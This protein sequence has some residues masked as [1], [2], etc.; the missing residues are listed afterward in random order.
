MNTNINGQLWIDKNSPYKL[1]YTANGSV[2]EMDT[3]IEYTIG[4]DET[5]EVGTLLA[6][7]SDIDS[8][9]VPC[10]VRKARFPEDL[11]N[12]I[13]IAGNKVTLESRNL[14]IMRSG[15]ISMT[16]EQA[17]NLLMTANLGFVKIGDPVYWY[18]GAYEVMSNPDGVFGS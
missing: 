11:D 6:F 1:K 3:A 5:F 2:F 13:G 7:S 4:G 14:S 8:N 17:M 9:N 16:T 12:I 18:I 15:V 10:V